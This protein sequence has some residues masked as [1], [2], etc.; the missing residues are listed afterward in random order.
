MAYG[1]GLVAMVAATLK[2]IEPVFGDTK[3]TPKIY[4]FNCGGRSAVRTG[5]RLVMVSYNLTHLHR[6]R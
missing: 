5:W 4:R 6:H 1:D 3:R 2:P